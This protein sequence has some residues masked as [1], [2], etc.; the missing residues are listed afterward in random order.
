MLPRLTKSWINGYLLTSVLLQ[1]R[2]T[3]SMRCQGTV[4]LMDVSPKRLYR[5]DCAY[6]FLEN[7]DA[8]RALMGSL[9]RQAVPLVRTSSD[10]RTGMGI[11]QP[12]FRC[13]SYSKESGC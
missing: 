9:Q 8:N 7:D 2:E 6:P 13:Y 11:R 5:G 4:E 12:G 10:Y 1:G 3:R